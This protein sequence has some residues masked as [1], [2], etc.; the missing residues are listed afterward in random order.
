MDFREGVDINLGVG[1]VNEE[2]IPGAEIQDALA[3]V[4]ARPGRYKSPLNYGGPKGSPTPIDSIRRC[5]TSRGVGGLT[6]DT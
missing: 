4:L 1:Y 3:G 2:T 6:E 5:H